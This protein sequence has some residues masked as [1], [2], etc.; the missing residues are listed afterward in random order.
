[1]SLRPYN[2]VAITVGSYGTCN[3]RT[4]HDARRYG[5]GSQ[6]GQLMRSLEHVASR[7]RDASNFLSTFVSAAALARLTARQIP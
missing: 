6:P 2:V 1:M 5:P 7:T 4:G 3:T